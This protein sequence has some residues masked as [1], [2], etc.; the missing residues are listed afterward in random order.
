MKG[1]KKAGGIYW[2]INKY[3]IGKMVL[4]INTWDQTDSEKCSRRQAKNGTQVQSVERQMAGNP[5]QDAI[6]V[7]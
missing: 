1:S 6:S 2:T 4:H 5:H 3:L 7:S